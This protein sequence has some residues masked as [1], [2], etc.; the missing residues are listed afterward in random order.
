MKLSDIRKEI[1]LIDDQIIA[2]LVQRLGWVAQMKDIKKSLTDP[3]RE[4]Q[5]LAKIDSVYIRNIYRSIFQTS[6]QM[7]KDRGFVTDTSAGRVQ[8]SERH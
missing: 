7:L 2:L 4:S 3:K 6:K 8:R 1:D 5:I